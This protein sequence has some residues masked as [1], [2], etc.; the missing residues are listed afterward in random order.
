[1]AVKCLLFIIPKKQFQLLLIRKLYIINSAF[2]Y[3]DEMFDARILTPR[4]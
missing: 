2:F 1:M 3:V 4:L